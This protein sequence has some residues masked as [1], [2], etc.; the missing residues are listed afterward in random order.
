[1]QDAAE[2]CKKLKDMDSEERDGR[3]LGFKPKIYADGVHE[4]TWGH[5]LY[6]IVE[7]GPYLC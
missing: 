4:A 1:M 7:K 2:Q 5:V 6:P 3:V